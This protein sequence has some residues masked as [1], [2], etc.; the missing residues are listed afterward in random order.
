LPANAALVGLAVG[1]LLVWSGA[2]TAPDGRLHV[3]FL[4]VGQGDSIL[5]TDPEGRQVLVD[6]GPDAS[7][8]LGQLGRHMPFWDRRIEMVVLSSS[9]EDHLGGLVSVVERYRVGQVLQGEFAEE[10]A[11]YRQ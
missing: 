11:T 1:A 10:T 2:L 6:G 3:A 5:I 4:D 8:T 7:L 9:D